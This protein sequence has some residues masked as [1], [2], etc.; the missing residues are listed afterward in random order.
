MTEDPWVHWISFSSKVLSTW[1]WVRWWDRNG[2][3]DIPR[4]TRQQMPVSA[5]RYEDRI[6]AW[7]S[8]TWI[9]KS[10]EEQWKA[11]LQRRAWTARQPAWPYGEHGEPG[12]LHWPQE[13]GGTF[14]QVQWR[15]AERFQAVTT[16]SDGYSKEITFVCGGLVAQSCPTLCDPMD[17]GP[18]GS[19]V[20]GDSPE[21]WSGLPCPPPGDFL[22]PGIEPRSPALQADSLP[23]EPPVKPMNTGVGSLSLLQG[24]IPTSESNWGLLHSRQIL[25]QLSYQ[26]RPR[27]PLSRPMPFLHL[28]CILCVRI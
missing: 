17:C 13:G 11:L 19:S 25:Y 1:S 15:A 18:P 8:R 20:Y 27:L 22:N 16:G 6:R 26:E 24:S 7:W 3:R 4:S 23:S 21:C 28:L 14:F 5:G 9:E 10:L 12:Q 2:G